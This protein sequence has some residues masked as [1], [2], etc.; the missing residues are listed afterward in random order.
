MFKNFSLDS[1]DIY[2]KVNKTNIIPFKLNNPTIS[3]NSI[4]NLQLECSNDVLGNITHHHKQNYDELI[5][6]NTIA[7]K[8]KLFVDRNTTT[9]SA[10]N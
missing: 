7:N 6:H 8:T 1:S 2:Y 9:D 5:G 4:H 10:F 3:I